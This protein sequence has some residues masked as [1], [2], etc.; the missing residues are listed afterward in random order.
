MT[1]FLLGLLVAACGF[2]LSALAVDDNEISATERS[3]LSVIT[4][5]PADTRN[6]TIAIS[7]NH[8]GDGE[9]EEL[10]PSIAYFVKDSKDYAT[11]MTVTDTSLCKRPVEQQICRTF[12]AFSKARHAVGDEIS[13]ARIGGSGFVTLFLT[14]LESKK[15]AGFDASIAFLG[16][17]TQDPPRGDVVLYVFATRRTNLIQLAAP[18]GQCLALKDERQSDVS[19]LKTSCL[20]KAVLQNAATKL[21]ELTDLFRVEPR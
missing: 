5:K 13:D 14:R 7:V 20:S 18:V 1:E 19:Y 16:I 2:P 9:G 4:T 17:D 6:L 10:P 21:S 3:Q 15:I 11:S 8:D 12:T